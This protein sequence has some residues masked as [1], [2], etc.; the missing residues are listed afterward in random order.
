[1]IHAYEKLS[2]TC[3][4]VNCEQGDFAGAVLRMAGHDFMDWNKKDRKGGSDGCV[5]FDDPDNAGLKPI[6]CGKG[7]FEKGATL[8]RVY[9]DFCRSVSYADFIVIAAEAMMIRTRPDYESATKSSPSLEFDFQ[10]GRKTATRCPKTEDTA[11]PNP[12]HGCPAVDDVF[13][14]RMEL[15][16]WRASAAL[17]GV[18]T[19]GRMRKQHSGFEGWWN[20]AKGGRTFNNDYYQ[21]MTVGWKAHRDVEKPEKSFWMRADSGPREDVFLDTDLCLYQGEDLLAQNAGQSCRWSDIEKSGGGNQNFCIGSNGKI[22]PSEDF[23]LRDCCGLGG[24]SGGR[25][26]IQLDEHAATNGESQKLNLTRDFNV[27]FFGVGRGPATDDIIEF[28]LDE[29]AWLAEFKKAW[30]KATENNLASR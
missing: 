14:R 12:A 15:N 3:D 25:S 17:M 7:E 28:A 29:S 16:S 30:K 10:F 9:K 18:H 13:N 8:N 22:N 11:L 27:R 19:L 2:S 21:S 4:A 1:M 23:P 5:D 20:S 24:S 26:L 6:L